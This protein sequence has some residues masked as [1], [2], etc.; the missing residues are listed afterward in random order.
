[1]NLSDNKMRVLFSNDNINK[2]T[3]DEKGKIREGQEDSSIVHKKHIK[4][5]PYPGS[6]K[7]DKQQD[8]QEEFITP[9]VTHPGDEE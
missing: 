5:H 7:S 8:N 1:M 2:S 3:D 9:P 4:D 6:S